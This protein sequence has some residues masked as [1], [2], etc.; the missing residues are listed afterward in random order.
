MMRVVALIVV[1]AMTPVNAGK[2]SPAVVLL[3][4]I[5]DFALDWSLVQPE[6]AKFTRVVAYDRGTDSMVAAAEELHARLHREKVKPP[7]VLVGHSWGGGIARVFAAKY[8][9]EVAG[10]V[11]VDSTHE[12]EMLWI[13]GKVLRPRL[14]PAEEW[15]T[16]WKP[17]PPDAK[18]FHPRVPSH[19][20]APFDKLP[21]D[22]QKQ[23]LAAMHDQVF[24]PIDFRKE[25]QTLHDLAGGDHPLGNRPL[26][27]LTRSLSD[28][29]DPLQEKDHLELQ[30]RLAELSRNGKQIVVPDSGHHIQLDQPSAVVDA[31]KQVVEA[32]RRGAR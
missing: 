7:Y 9:A 15:A 17:P 5:G 13:N 3:S 29:D 26:I 12:D 1:F 22:V 20:G 19:L 27:V 21:P 16:L 8:P 25:L 32:V 30:R 6:I 31:V 18:P 2:G 11:L 28:T 4:G 10:M 14:A 24:T 23:R